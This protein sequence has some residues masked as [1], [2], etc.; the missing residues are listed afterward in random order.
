MA[1]RDADAGTPV[2]QVCRELAISET[3]F[4]R[5]KKRYGSQTV[6]EPREL[7][8]E[9]RQLREENSKLRDLVA[10]LSVENVTLQ[11]ALKGEP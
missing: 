8:R 3:T 1:L 9:L 4:Y 2:A 5:W 11:A 6:S 10:D 7:R